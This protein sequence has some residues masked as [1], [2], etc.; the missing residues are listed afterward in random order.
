M[1]GAGVLADDRMWLIGYGGGPWLLEADGGLFEDDAGVL[2]TPG[3]PVWLH[4]ASLGDGAGFVA[5]REDGVVRRFDTSMQVRDEVLVP[6]ARRAVSP[7]L[8]A[9]LIV[10]DAQGVTLGGRR[11]GAHAEV[12]ALA[13][14]AAA[15]W[16]AVGTVDGVLRIHALPGGEVLA[17]A[18]LHDERISALAF[19]D[20]ELVSVSWDRSVRRWSLA[21]L[22]R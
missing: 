11:L 14:D 9:P 22:V 13:V 20:V 15:R 12:T 17:Q 7:S 8:S 19:S 4:G 3:V 5:V 16:L 2:E 21:P 18:A 10:G 6:G 1:R